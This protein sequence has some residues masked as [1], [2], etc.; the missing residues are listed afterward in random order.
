M[1]PENQTLTVLY[2]TTCKNRLINFVGAEIV[3]LLD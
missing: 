3:K 1:S 2:D